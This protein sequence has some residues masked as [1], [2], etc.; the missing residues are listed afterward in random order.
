MMM[1]QA[2]YE[3][4]HKIAMRLD[5]QYNELLRRSGLLEKQ[6]DLIM[7]SLNDMIKDKAWVC[8]DMCLIK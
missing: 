4:M 7:S 5:E 2:R 6:H 3:R 1:T 8:T